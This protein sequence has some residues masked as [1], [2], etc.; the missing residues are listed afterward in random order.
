MLSNLPVSGYLIALL[1]ADN[2]FMP[3][4]KTEPLKKKLN[5][6]LSHLDKIGVKYEKTKQLDRDTENYSDIIAIAPEDLY[7]VETSNPN[8]NV[9]NDREV[10]KEYLVIH[11]D[12][13]TRQMVEGRLNGNIRSDE[14]SITYTKDQL[15][16]YKKIKKT[17]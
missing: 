11:N 17:A 12:Y 3:L 8:S 16:G 9:I 15:D 2:I 6:I 1:P 5:A 10:P 7:T 14:D 13:Q 4:K